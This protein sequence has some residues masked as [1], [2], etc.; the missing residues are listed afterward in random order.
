[1][2]LRLSVRSLNVPRLAMGRTAVISSSV[3]YLNI[4]S[5]PSDLVG[6]TPLLDL[7]VILKNHGVDTDKNGTTLGG[8]TRISRSLFLRQGSFGKKYD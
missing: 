5:K 3:R 8:K 7:N 4:A 1:M 2:T 6:N